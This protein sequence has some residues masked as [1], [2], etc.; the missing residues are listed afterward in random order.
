MYDCGLSQWVR[1]FLILSLA[2]GLTQVLA[3]SDRPAVGVCHRDARNHI[4]N[5]VYQHYYI[6]RD[7]ASA[8]TGR[9]DDTDRDGKPGDSGESPQMVCVFP[10][11]LVLGWATA[12]EIAY[13]V[14]F[15]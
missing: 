15:W 14:L 13:F 10:A 9:F 11:S 7:G 5:S 4:R 2:R 6:H 1:C 8:V 12:V 3:V